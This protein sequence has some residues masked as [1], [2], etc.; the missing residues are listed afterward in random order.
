MTFVITLWLTL[1]FAVVS[2]LYASVGQAGGSGYL[3]AMALFGVSPV[4][5]KPTALVLNVLVA[6]LSTLKFSHAG[7]FSW[8]IFWP[9]A[10]T[11]VPAAFIGGTLSVSSSIYNIIVGGALLYAALQ[12]FRVTQV[13]PSLGV[14]SPPL[15]LALSAGAAVGLLSGL[16]GIGGG[17]MFGPLLLSLRWAETRQTLGMSA[18]LNLTNSAA[19]TLGNLSSVMALPSAM[20]LWAAAAMLGGWVGSEYGSR[21]VSQL[22]L[23]RLL[24]VVLVIAGFKLII[25]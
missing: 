22:T 16:T 15:W 25:T 10:V 21:R 17:I 13:A 12:L 2:M 3:A 24:A 8:A 5:M 23:Q 20:F 9:F 14:Q 1:S 18:A 4:V 7:Y 11:S 19:G 6:T